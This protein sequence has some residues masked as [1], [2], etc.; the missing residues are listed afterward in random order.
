ML[1]A[2]C[3]P[4][5]CVSSFTAFAI[6]AGAHASMATYAF[7]FEND[8][9]VHTDQNYTNGLFLDYNSAAKQHTD[10]LPWFSLS[11]LPWLSD[12]QEMLNKV[13]YRFGH[14]LWTPEDI[15]LTEPEPDQRPYAA[16]MFVETSV[17]Q[18]SASRVDNYRLMIGAV[19]EQAQGDHFQKYIHRSIDVN[20]P[21]GWAYQ[22][23]DQW[24]LN[25]GFET[26]RLIHR[27]SFFS[28]WQYD[29]SAKGRASLGNYQTEM[30]TGLITRFGKNLDQ[31]FGGIG[32]TPGKFNETPQYAADGSTGYFAYAGAEG[33][34][35]PYDI[36]VD[37]DRPGEVS[38]NAEVLQAT[39][40]AGLVYYR[41]RWGT[42]ISLSITS[43][44]FEQSSHTYTAT[45]A[46]G[47]FWK[48]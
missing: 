12:R 3:L 2:R 45:G 7:T 35:R 38:T 20:E 29:I 34:Y 28:R 31:S 42:N 18:F 44:E 15:A 39:A 4:A 47:I 22:I 1:T 11:K 19:G 9:M 40:V 13:G 10:D 17:K 14:Q 48:M 41:Q 36:T 33:R 23:D 24:V 27:D 30:A 25:A 8:T 46:W 26:D 21:M 37:G 43:K 6:P 5:F 32:F 16:L